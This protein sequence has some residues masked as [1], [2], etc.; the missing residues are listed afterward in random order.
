M[1]D[2]IRDCNNCVYSTRDGGCR[3]WKCFGNVTVE[4]IEKSVW[5]DFLSFLD[6]QMHYTKEQIDKIREVWENRE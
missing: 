4:D 6:E 3:K 5:D 1:K 2:I